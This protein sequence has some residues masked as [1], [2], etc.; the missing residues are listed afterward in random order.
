[1]EEIYQLRYEVEKREAQEKLRK[2]ERA[3]LHCERQQIERTKAAKACAAAAATA[4]QKKQEDMT[5]ATVQLARI[6]LS[7][8]G[9]ARDRSSCPS[10]E[11]EREVVHT[12]SADSAKTMGAQKSQP[13]NAFPNQSSRGPVWTTL[14]RPVSRMSA[15]MRELRSIIVEAEVEAKMN[16]NSHDQTNT[17]K[18]KLAS[19]GPE[20]E[21]KVEKKTPRKSSN[22]PQKQASA[23]TK[24]WALTR[25]R[26]QEAKDSTEWVQVEGEEDLAPV[27]KDEFIAPVSK[28]EF[29]GNAEGMSG[30]EMKWQVVSRD[31]ESLA[32]ESEWEMDMS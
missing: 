3:G 4:K 11:R 14:H 6:A 19:A 9:A 30:E 16:P 8:D 10:P 21:S 22:Q 32:D 31:G 27:S 2:D 25:E 23:L 12:T 29:M 26:Q 13:G 24:L 15:K 5:M 1:M 28:D 20:S 18:A 7:T 17:W